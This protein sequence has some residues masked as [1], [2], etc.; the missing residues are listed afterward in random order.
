MDPQRKLELDQIYEAVFMA[1]DQVHAALG[2]GLEPELYL[3]CVTHELGLMKVTVQR[4]I[5]VPVLYRELRIEKGTLLPL[6]VN[7]LAVVNARSEPSLTAEH[8]MAI[9]AQLRVSGL[10][11]GILLG[12][13]TP[14]IRGGMRRVMNP[15]PRV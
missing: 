2:R 3:Q 9:Q 12:F 4:N 15:A 6:V 11:M 8:D 10:P 14:S 1:A 13:G 5:A 7:G